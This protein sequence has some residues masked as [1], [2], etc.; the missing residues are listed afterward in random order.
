EVV[1]DGWRRSLGLQESRVRA[2][3]E[4]HPNAAQRGDK[5]CSDRDVCR[6]PKITQTVL[7][8][9]LFKQILRSRRLIPQFFQPH[10]VIKLRDTPAQLRV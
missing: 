7:S 1:E 4:Q 6:F 5:P 3:K 8:D 10:G 2:P 9:H